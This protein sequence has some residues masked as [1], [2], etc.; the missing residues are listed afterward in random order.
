MTTPNLQLQ[1]LFVLNAEGRMTGTREPGSNRPPVLSLVRSG[2]DCAWAVRADVPDDLAAELAR[3]ARQER[4]TPDLR[5]PPVHADRF[6]SL[7]HG[8]IESGPAFT[9]PE[10]FP[11]PA[12]VV[13]LHDPHAGDRYFPW[14][15]EEMDGRSPV[16]AELEDGQ[17]V[18]I[19][20]CAR[21]SDVAAEAGLDTVEAFRGRGSGPRVTAAWALAIRSSGRVPLYSTSW[22]NQASLAVARKLGLVAYASDWSLYD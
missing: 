1:T 17:A 5:V 6:V 22:S 12:G 9:F 2:T 3:L 4:P 11:A 19:C 7:V 10:A 13:L 21:R 20:F 18:S 8:R 15:D 16:L 14:L